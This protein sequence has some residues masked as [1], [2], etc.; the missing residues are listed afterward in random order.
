MMGVGGGSGEGVENE[1]E[2]VDSE[3]QAVD[4]LGASLEESGM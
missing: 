4:R 2:E 1:E 3:L